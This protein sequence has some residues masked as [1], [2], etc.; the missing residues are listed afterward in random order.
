MLFMILGKIRV[1]NKAIEMLM[2]LYLDDARVRA[3]IDWV[4][5]HYP[6]Y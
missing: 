3:S 6:Y 4:L 1:S 5:S 2:T